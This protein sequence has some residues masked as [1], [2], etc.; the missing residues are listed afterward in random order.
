[1]LSFSGRKGLDPKPSTVATT[2]PC[3]AG[4]CIHHSLCGWS[5]S[6]QCIS[7][8][9]EQTK[10]MHL[11]LLAACLFGTMTD[12]QWERLNRKNLLR[13]QSLDDPGSEPMAAYKPQAFKAAG[14]GHCAAASEMH[15]Y[16]HV[17]GHIATRDDACDQSNCWLPDCNDCRALEAHTQNPAV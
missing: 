9:P 10:R 1:M 15:T 16:M 8:L 13:A 2:G 12:K 17:C 11:A 3:F 4:W 14:A 5:P 7:A 6:S